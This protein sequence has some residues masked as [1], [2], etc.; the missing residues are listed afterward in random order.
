ML[1]AIVEV[2]LVPVGDD[3]PGEG[4][5]DAELAERIQRARRFDCPAARVG[6]RPCYVSSQ[7]GL[8]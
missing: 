2:I 8:T 6:G 5:Q 3:Y 7:A 1:P 4:G